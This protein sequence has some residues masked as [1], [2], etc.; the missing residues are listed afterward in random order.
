MLPPRLPQFGQHATRMQ[1]VV[2]QAT[3]GPVCNL[4]FMSFATLA[5]ERRTLPDLQAKVQTSRQCTSWLIIYHVHIVHHI[6]HVALI[7]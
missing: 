1:V 5:L 2:D 6:H 3:Y 7:Q 4:L